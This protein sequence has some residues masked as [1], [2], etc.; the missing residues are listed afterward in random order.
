MKGD[1]ACRRVENL[2]PAQNMAW[3]GNKFGKS[4][5]EAARLLQ[6]LEP[7][8]TKSQ[9]LNF[10][11][12]EQKIS[13]EP[14]ITGDRCGS[15][16]TTA[17]TCYTC[18]NCQLPNDEKTAKSGST[19]RACKMSSTFTGSG[20]PSDITANCT[21]AASDVSSTVILER[22]SDVSEGLRA[23]FPG[24]IGTESPLCLHVIMVGIGKFSVERH[25]AYDFLKMTN[26][27]SSECPH[28]VL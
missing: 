21:T 4:E 15:A 17:F 24:V 13:K 23:L 20:T 27:D 16:Q 3:N 26:G 1:L 22:N 25:L 5:E 9:S 6:H 12:S 28:K 2:R 11:K 14:E 10:G 8:C 18:M 7:A 19:F